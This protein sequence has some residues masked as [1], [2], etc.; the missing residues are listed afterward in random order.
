[1]R[2]LV[3]MLAVCG[4]FVGAAPVEAQNIPSFVTA[5]A[6]YKDCKGPREICG[7]YIA[8]VA[9]HD[10]DMVS[11]MTQAHIA[12]PAQFCIPKAKTLHQVTDAFTTFIDSH[13]GARPSVASEVVV[14]ALH[15]AFPCPTK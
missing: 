14:V 4:L 6:L 3:A 7:G 8:G 11:V 12:M 15:D 2:V 9:D 13:A 5:D 1:M 10:N